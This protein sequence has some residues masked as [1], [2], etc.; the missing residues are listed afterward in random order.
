MGKL[1]VLG[2][3]SVHCSLPTARYPAGSL[4]DEVRAQLE[5]E[6]GRPLLA[7]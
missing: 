7:P 2:P 4:G 6:W 5:M 3:G 1:H